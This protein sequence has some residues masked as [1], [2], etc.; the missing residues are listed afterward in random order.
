[1][2]SLQT[3]W[4]FKVTYIILVLILKAEGFSWTEKSFTG[5][6]GSSL[7]KHCMSCVHITKFLPLTST[8]SQADIFFFCGSSPIHRPSVTF[9]FS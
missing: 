8:H 6:L 5:N 9:A 1:M 2:K 4:I 3:Q 7:G